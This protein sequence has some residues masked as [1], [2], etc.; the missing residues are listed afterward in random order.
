MGEG[1]RKEEH[2]YKQTKKVQQT[3]KCIGDGIMMFMRKSNLGELQAFEYRLSS[4][5]YHELNK[6]KK[7]KNNKLPNAKYQIPNTKY[8]ILSTNYKIS[9]TINQYQYQKIN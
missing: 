4:K 5:E 6:T 2:T 3:A 1:S 9:Y 8:Q 7:K